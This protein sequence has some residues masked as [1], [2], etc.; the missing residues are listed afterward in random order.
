MS[1]KIACWGNKGLLNSRGYCLH[2]EYKVD[3][4]PGVVLYMAEASGRIGKMLVLDG[5]F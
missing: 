4:N 3:G 5:N 2:L 1:I